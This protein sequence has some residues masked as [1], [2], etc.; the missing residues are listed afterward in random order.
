MKGSNTE[1]Y[2]V[3][4][5][6][7]DAAICNLVILVSHFSDDY[8]D[9]QWLSLTEKEIEFLIVELIESLASELNGETLILLLRKIRT[10]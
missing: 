4:S 6:L 10:E 9:S 2:S 5:P 7:I 3:P 8:F 1:D